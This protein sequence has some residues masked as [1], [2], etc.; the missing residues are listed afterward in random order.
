MLVAH[1]IKGK[2]RIV[3]FFCGIRL[4]NSLNIR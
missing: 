2:R 4:T 1:L 3:L